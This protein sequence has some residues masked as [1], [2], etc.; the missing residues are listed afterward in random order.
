MDVTSNPYAPPEVESLADVALPPDTEFL[1]NDKCLAV[2]EHV[3]LPRLCVITG[4]PVPKQ[5]AKITTLWWIPGLIRLP[6]LISSVILA[7]ITLA[8]VGGVMQNIAVGNDS[9]T[10]LRRMLKEISGVSVVAAGFMV[11]LVLCLVYG[12]RIQMTWFVS[13]R[14]IRRYR[15]RQ[16]VWTLVWLAVP[17]IIV[18]LRHTTRYE[19]VGQST[20]FAAFAAITIAR[21]IRGPR[22]LRVIGR[23]NGLFL[24]MGLSDR[25]LEQLRSLMRRATDTKS[26]IENPE[27]GT[28]STGI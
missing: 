28:D 21:W 10:V 27:T 14:E 1:F 9:T 12:R 2:A 24:V 11:L 25:F 6:L 3:E 26:E 18:S 8:F 20:F 16:M 13:Q 22:P 5:F 19:F 15:R 4:T 17:A 23:F 7:L